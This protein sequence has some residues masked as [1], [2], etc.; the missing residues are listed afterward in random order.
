MTVQK[1][2]EFN[3][4]ARGTPA[5]ERRATATQFIEMTSLT[6]FRRALS[7]RAFG[8]HARQRV[9]IARA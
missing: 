1:N 4:K 8:R 6:G 7:A 3:M 2:V 9:G 5:A